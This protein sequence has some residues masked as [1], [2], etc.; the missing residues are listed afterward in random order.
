MLRAFVI[1]LCLSLPVSAA[2]QMLDGADDPAYQTALSTL[3]ARDDPAA[4]ATLRDLAESGNAAALVALPFALTWVPPTGSLKEK[5]AQRMVGGVKAHVAAAEAHGATALWG[6]GDLGDPMSLPDR[7]TS[8]IALGEPGKAAMLMSA[9]INQTGDA[10]EALPQLLSDDMPAM[11]GAL[12]LAYRLTNG[13]YG[14]EPAISDAALLLSLMRENRLAAWLAYVH[15]LERQPEIFDV[16]GNPLA[17]TGLSAADTEARIAAARAVHEVWFNYDDAP[18][19]A[20]S[21]TLARESLASR[22]EFQPVTQLCQ[23]HCPETRTACET[24]VLAY[25]GLPFGYQTWQPFADVLDPLA[26]AASDRGLA[27]LIPPRRDPAAAADRAT[28]EGLDACY[29]GVLARRAT[30]PFGP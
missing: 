30:N 14:T 26:F 17:G 4:V 19:T 24:A 7:A 29:A 23:A 8:L 27:V 2:A 22:T 21:A 16:L 11:L 28:A 15:V 6:G 3:L 5:N 25:P 1:P 12:A 10:G 9:W 20:A 18:V 13:A